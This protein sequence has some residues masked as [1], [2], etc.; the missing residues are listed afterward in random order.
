MPLTHRSPDLRRLCSRLRRLTTVVAGLVFV[1]AFVA[2]CSF[3]QPTP[4]PTA[5]ASPTPAP[6]PTAEPPAA[7]GGWYV[8]AQ[9]EQPVR[10]WADLT[11]GEIEG[12][13]R[14]LG[15]R[16]PKLKVEWRRGADRQLYQ[17]SLADA[18]AGG[19]GWDVYVGDSGPLLRSSQ[20][21]L[22]WTPPEARTVPP[23][24]V[25]P[26]GAWYAVASTY[27]VVQYNNE[28]VSPQRIPK[29]YDDLLDPVFFGRLA[30]EDQDLI[31]LR[32]LVETR[33]RES[34]I[35]LVRA[36]AQQSVTF[37]TDPRTLV[38]FVTSGQQSVGIDARMDVVER[39]R[40]AGGKTAW[41]GV[42]PVPVQPLAMVVSVATDRPNATRL[43][44]NYLLSQDV[45]SVLAH[46]GRTPSRP[47]VD[48]EPAT[49]TRGLRP[50]V[51]LPPDASAERELVDLWRELWGRR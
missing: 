28:Q 25:D 39:E 3:Q 51:V 35:E 14:L 12:I 7:V 13:E 4:A 33:G 17:Q 47:D 15:Q 11:A 2:A 41:I 29:T 40:R 20:V 45:Q 48:T 50:R 24:L 37:R 19:V 30:I 46:A 38:V 43:V 49:L 8:A 32:S 21:A 42:D 22:R 5:V 26:E 10:V 34:T 9:S 31:W 23:E 18:R 36:L 44:A 27:H 6:R 16:Y 1:L